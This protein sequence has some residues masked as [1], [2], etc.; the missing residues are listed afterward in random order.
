MP[1]KKILHQPTHLKSLSGKMICQ[2]HCGDHHMLAMST[3]GDL[4]GWGG[5]EYGQLGLG[6]VNDILLP[7]PLNFFRK[8]GISYVSCGTVHNAAI[9]KVGTLYTWGRSR[10]LRL[11]YRRDSDYQLTPIAVESI[12]N[13]TFKQVSCGLLHTVALSTTGEVWAFGCGKHGQL[14]FPKAGMLVSEEAEENISFPSK[15][16]SIKN[17][18]QV[19]CGGY[20]TC[21]LF[22]SS[23]SIILQY[24]RDGDLQ[25][26]KEYLEFRPNNISLLKKARDSLTF[27][28]PFLIAVSLNHSTFVSY[29]T[30]NI[31]DLN[32]NETDIQGK[33]AL[34]ISVENNYLNL[35][36]FLVTLKKIQ[37]NQQD[38]SLKTPLHLALIK[39]YYSIAEVLIQAGASVDIQ[40]EE[41]EN[42]LDLCSFEDAFTFKKLAKKHD[43]LLLYHGTDDNFVNKL[44]AE[45]ETYYIKCCYDKQDDLSIQNSKA[46]IFVC[47]KRYKFFCLFAI[48]TS[49]FE[50]RSIVRTEHCVAR[51][52][53]SK[54]IG[55]LIFPIWL[56]KVEFDS[57]ME[58]LVFRRQLVDF[59]NSSQFKESVSLLVSGLRKIFSN[60]SE[61]A[62]L[63]EN[64]GVDDSK[65]KSKL[66][67]GDTVFICYDQ[68]D[69]F[70]AEKLSNLL[71]K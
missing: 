56:E 12:R 48:L 59:S 9:S 52:K 27:Y 1:D 14:G 11:G 44:A 2:I 57:E 47:S 15:I 7:V 46:I 33:T 3:E 49:S 62:E 67:H 28:T 50:N 39:K 13:E 41:G 37:I 25:I 43:V 31:P 26:L 17:V 58:A 10:N 38:R 64:Q 65:S 55:K 68:T 24:A 70:I 40:D 21:F 34:H 35:V 19:I 63:S 30:T 29:L 60:A 53:F 42:P 66:K 45:I 16:P 18:S 71:E 69:K 5:N 22:Q 54:Q 20:H 8:I 61:N 32:I 23:E 4:W 36:K 51:L 6:H